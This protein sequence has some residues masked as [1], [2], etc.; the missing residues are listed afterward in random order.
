M[1]VLLIIG[2]SLSAFSA[3]SVKAPLTPTQLREEA[4]QI[5]RGTISSVKHDRRCENRTCTDYTVNSV[6]TLRAVSCERQNAEI[7]QAKFYE[8]VLSQP[9]PGDYGHYPQPQTGETGTLYVKNGNIVH[10]NG[11]VPDR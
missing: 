7:V 9:M 3:N 10:P 2:L 5:C 11:W 4:D 1:K 8:I 6:A